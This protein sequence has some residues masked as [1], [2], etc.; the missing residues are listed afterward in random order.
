MKIFE[1]LFNQPA[2]S[3][4][5]VDTSGQGNNAEINPV[6]AGATPAQVVSGFSPP[7][8]AF[9]SL[10]FSVDDMPTS[11][12]AGVEP[13]DQLQFLRVPVTPGVL[14]INT[15]R[16]FTI[17]FWAYH[18][19]QPDPGGNPWDGPRTLSGKEQFCPQHTCGA[20][21]FYIFVRTKNIGSSVPVPERGELAFT[22]DGPEIVQDGGID[23]T[24]LGGTT[25][26]GYHVPIN[27]WVHIACV[28]RPPSVATSGSWQ[29]FVDGDL[30][31]QKSALAGLADPATQIFSTDPA[32][33]PA[34]GVD[35][36]FGNFRGDFPPN[37]VRRPRPIQAGANDYAYNGYLAGI[38]MYDHAQS[39]TEIQDDIDTDSGSGGIKQV[40][41]FAWVAGT[42]TYRFGHVS[43]PTIPIT[44]APAD[45]DRSRWAMLHDGSVYRM[46]FF[47]SGTND[48]LYQFGFNGSSYAFGHRSIPELTL[49]G[50]PADADASSFSML[51][52]GS[53][54]RLYLRQQGNPRA[55]YQFVWEPGTTTYRW[56]FGGAI[57]RIEVTGFPAD[58]DWS[59]WAMLHDRSAYR[60]YA[61]RS[62]SN[63]QFYQGAFNP[64]TGEYEFGHRSIP[65]LTLVDTPADSDTQS[66]SMLHDGSNYRFYFQTL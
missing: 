52:D 34:P 17:S 18:E 65:E 56:G 9:N 2:G 27:T 43:I 37:G 13:D 11:H 21:A 64:S 26:D 53:A 61:F 23:T 20:E 62:G 8:Y 3:T 14:N 4:N 42:T 59:R 47:K 33:N 63:T 25:S 22:G 19:V 5:I 24:G 49:T 32:G 10:K 44:G 38:R 7:G 1:Y 41:Q 6:R 60:F 66:F 28:L 45:T 50:A 51:H 31:G 39:A 54:Y 29:I 35:I 58:T 16:A 30:K 15:T 36:R 46:Y 55:L 48:T 12:G 40:N 57:P